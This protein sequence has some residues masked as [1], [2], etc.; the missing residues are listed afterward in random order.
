MKMIL[1]RTK[2]MN[3]YCHRNEDRLKHLFFYFSLEDFSVMRE[4]LA[5]KESELEKSKKTVESV[6]KERQQLNINLQKVLSLS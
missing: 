6:T 5:F 4:N 1:H 2:S 3:Y